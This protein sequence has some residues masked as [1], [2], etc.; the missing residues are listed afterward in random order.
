MEIIL[1]DHSKDPLWNNQHDGTFLFFF[2]FVFGITV[3]GGGGGFGEDVFWTSEKHGMEKT[4]WVGVRWLRFDDFYFF[5]S[6][7]W[8]FFQRVRLGNR[9]VVYIFLQPN[10]GLILKIHWKKWRKGH[11][12][13]W[14]SIAMENGPGLKM[15]FLVNMGIFHGYVSLP[16]GN[17]CS[18]LFWGGVM[19]GWNHG[20]IRVNRIGDRS[21][22]SP[23]RGVLI[24]MFPPRFGASKDDFRKNDFYRFFT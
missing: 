5:Y 9:L 23:V 15:H 8:V 2:M 17:Y 3:N 16:E 19:L 1:T 4:Q 10:P 7:Q 21:F 14:T 22:C 13:R 6:F 24:E 20:Q 11:T 18:F 12:L